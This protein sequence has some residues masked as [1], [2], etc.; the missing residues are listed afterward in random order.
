M[1]A[2]T[3]TTWTS[4]PYVDRFGNTQYE[5]TLIVKFLT[6]DS[7]Y[8]TYLVTRLDSNSLRN[9]ILVNNNIIMASID[10]GNVYF[11]LLNPDG[12]GSICLITVNLKTRH[13]HTQDLSL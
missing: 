3:Y 4:A 8:S 1:S 10:Q 9:R 13:I 6:N 5:L 11:S 2:N 7:P 12:F